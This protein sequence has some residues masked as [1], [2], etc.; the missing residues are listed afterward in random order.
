MERVSLASM[1]EGVSLASMMEGVSLIVMEDPNV[2]GPDHIV[3]YL[4]TEPIQCH[5]MCTLPYLAIY[6][7]TGVSNQEPF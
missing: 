4:Y 5:S 3:I 6:V 1:M 2:K 7:H